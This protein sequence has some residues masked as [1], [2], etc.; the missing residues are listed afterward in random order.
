MA[1]MA[2]EAAPTLDRLSAINADGSRRHIQPADVE[3]TF[4]T[5]RHGVYAVLIAIYL[6]MPFV[7]FGGHPAM[8]FDIEHRSFYLFGAVFN[9]QDV[10]RMAFLLLTVGL[11]LFF[12]T[13]WYGRVWCGWACPQTVFLE[14]VFRRVERLLE[15]P[16]EKR[17]RLA[18][19]PFSFD[20]LWR[21]ATKHVV[22][23]AVA[24]I[25]ANVALAFF[26]S[27]PSMLEMTRRDPRENWVPF[28]WVMAFTLGMYFNFAWFREQLCIVICPYGRL[29]SALLDRDSVII[30]YDAKRG[31]PRGKAGRAEKVGL[32]VVSNNVATSK[33]DCV[34][35]G[36]CVTVCP[37]G[38]DIR[39]GTQ[40]ECVG[41]AQCIDACDDVMA[42]LSRPKGLIRYDSESG[43][44]GQKRRVIRP[45]LVTYAVLL[46]AAITGLVLVTMGRQT[47][48]ANVIRVRGMPYVIENGGIRNQFEIHLVNKNPAPTTFHLDVVC[49]EPLDFAMPV[50]D[51]TVGALE[52][53]RLPIFATSKQSDW[54]GPFDMTLKISDSASGKHIEVP[55]RF[56]GPP[57][58]IH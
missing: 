35:C 15:G 8:Q 37:T 49:H 19:A 47:F 39:N 20:K 27:F 16:R 33:G 13:A 26:V 52:H 51:V 41:C 56:L 1:T 17:I 25:L 54:H 42:R 24:L 36:R 3:G 2:K 48:D 7:H 18:A 43:L 32:P 4:I 30:G 14:G 6:L 53:F 9:A 34:D 38:I 45:R 31:E 50:H 40:M 11:S 28:V 22:Y 44:D 55:M 21:K 10:W 58:A 46:T 29:Q 23:F 57:G 5:A 12:L